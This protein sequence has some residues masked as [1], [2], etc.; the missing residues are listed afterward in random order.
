MFDNSCN[1]NAFADNALIVS[2]MNIKNGEKQPLLRNSIMLDSLPHSMIFTDVNS[3]I[4][5]KSIR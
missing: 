3:I 1:Y 2:R 4:K 5:P